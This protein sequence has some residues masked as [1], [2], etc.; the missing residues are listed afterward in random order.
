M[1]YQSKF[2]EFFDTLFMLL[3]NTESSIGQ[4]TPLHVIHHAVMGPIMWLIV[5]VEPGGNSFFGPCINSFIHTV[6]YGYYF[7]ATLGYRAP[8][9]QYLTQMQMIQFV[10]ILIHSVFHLYSNISRGPASGRADA[11]LVEVLMG[12]D[13]YWPSVLGYVE[14]FL[15]ILMLVMFGDFYL[16]SYSKKK[17][18]KAAKAAKS[19]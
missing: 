2:L 3:R 11:S 10:A 17:A 18:E 13:T 14:F 6:M 15:M 16:K 19:S 12:T 4:V 5:T 8:W 9:K 1:N 7:A